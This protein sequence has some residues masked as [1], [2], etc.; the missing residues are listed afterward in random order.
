MIKNLGQL[1]DNPQ[2]LRS[3]PQAAIAETHGQ[4]APRLFL[5]TAAKAIP[6]ARHAIPYDRP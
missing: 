6:A 3:F 2:N 1:E 4:Q 5:R